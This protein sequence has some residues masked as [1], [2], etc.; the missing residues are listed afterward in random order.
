[1]PELPEVETIRRG[2]AGS[3]IGKKITGFDSDWQKM[4]NR[5]LAEYRRILAGK[6]IKEVERRAKMLI[7]G[8]GGGWR[9]WF[10]LK[11]TGQLVYS[12]GKKKVVGGHPIREGFEHDPNRFTHATFAFSD[13]SHLFFNDVRK[14]G[15]VRLYQGKEL[16]AK[17]EAM[18]LGPEPLSPEFN[19]AFFQKILKKKPNAKIKAFLM[20]PQN[21]VGLGNIYS[22]EVCYYARVRPDRKVKNLKDAEI[23]LMFKGIKAILTDAIKH[24]GTSFSD[25]VNALGEA[26]A[27]T[28]K[29]KVYQRF[30]LKC[31]RCG[32]KVSRMKFGG[33]TSHF[34]PACQK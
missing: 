32:G 10:H 28:K 2:L 13:G 21:V 12:S 22:D 18:K 33:R 8:L 24:E 26:G 20:D 29:L 4:L 16:A 1:M 14:F 27:Y 9:L 30:G 5:P 31:C 34:C 17:L 19:L 6:R 3:I 25:Y 7:I 11:M 15:W 23:K